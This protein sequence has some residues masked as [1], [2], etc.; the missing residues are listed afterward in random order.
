MRS[1]SRATLGLFSAAAIGCL[2]ALSP[3]RAAEPDGL[4]A[5]IGPAEALRIAIVTRASEK[6]AKGAAEMKAVADYYS[7]SE[8]TLLWVDDNGLNARAKSVMEEIGKADEYG[9][10][11]SDYALP[12]LDNFDRKAPNATAAMADAEIKLDIAVLRYARDA[13]GGRF[14]WTKINPN[15]DPTLALP[16]PLQVMESM[17][18]RSDPAVYLRSFQPDQPQFQAL[19]KALIAARGGNVEEKKDDVVRIPDGPVLKIGVEHEQVALLRKRLD[20]PAADPAKENVFDA[21][22]EE[23]TGRC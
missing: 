3:V 13:R 16:D 11:A 9:L 2:A 12:K 4:A 20:V 6:G 23:A 1:S 22:V 5:L 8:A 19:R 18:I 7:D 15:L 17:A 21:T 14:D 10:R